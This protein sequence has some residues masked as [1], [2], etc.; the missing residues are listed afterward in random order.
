MSIVAPAGRDL[1]GAEAL[2]PRTGGGGVVPALRLFA[3]NTIGASTVTTSP[4]FE[5][6]GGAISGPAESV[7]VAGGGGG[8]VAVE[9]ADGATSFEAVEL[10]GAGVGASEFGVAGAAAGA[11]SEAGGLAGEAGSAGAGRTGAGA[12]AA[13]S[14]VFGALAGFGVAWPSTALDGIAV[15]G[16]F[17]TPASNCAGAGG[18]QP[19]SS[20]TFASRWSIC[21]P[22]N[23]ACS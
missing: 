20:G 21:P 22:R 14:T 19:H 16:R 12:A 8:G 23:T 9:G 7:V 3:L 15:S 6:G 17:C 5:A 11:A 1:A 13:A 10:A 18:G 2:S 4:G